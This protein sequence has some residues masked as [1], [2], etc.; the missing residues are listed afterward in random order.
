MTEPSMVQYSWGGY[1]PDV[2]KEVNLVVPPDGGYR[3]VIH[4][5]S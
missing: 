3:V 5:P 2:A 1:S 4:L